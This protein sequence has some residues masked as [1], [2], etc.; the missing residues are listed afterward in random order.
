ML[1][2]TQYDNFKIIMPT[3]KTPNNDEAGAAIAIQKTLIPE[4]ELVM[5][6][7]TGRSLTLVH[8]LDIMITE[9]KEIKARDKASTTKQTDDL[10]AEKA[11]FD[12]RFTAFQT[13]VATK[14]AEVLAETT[15]NKE[16]MLSKFIALQDKTNN[17]AA[18]NTTKFAELNG[19]VNS[20]YDDALRKMDA[21]DKLMNDS[22]KV[23]INEVRVQSEE[24]DAKRA[25]IGTGERDEMERRSTKERAE[26]EAKYAA[27][28]TQFDSFERE[29]GTKLGAATSTEKEGLVAMQ[30]G[31]NETVGKFDSQV[32]ELKQMIAAQAEEFAR[33]VEMMKYFKERKERLDSNDEEL[34]KLVKKLSGTTGKTPDSKPKVEA[35]PK[36]ILESEKKPVMQPIKKVTNVVSTNETREAGRKSPALQRAR[37]GNQ[38]RMEKPKP[39]ARPPPPNG[40]GFSA[41]AESDAMYRHAMYRIP[42]AYETSVVDEVF[43]QYGFHL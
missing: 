33:Y 32:N 36:A 14:R 9:I 2:R 26:L 29:V 5:A 17:E 6:A 40:K 25:E 35:E 11:D 34:S 28:K 24:R 23:M 22:L 27:L 30:K 18:E 41:A 20:N 19:K 43:E 15:K 16:E 8:L 12:R 13:E 3:G 10:A 21:A 4:V 37:K 38:D 31:I 7:D 42:R 1:R 39:A